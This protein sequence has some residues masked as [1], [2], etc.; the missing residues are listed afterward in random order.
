M[1]N[2]DPARSRRFFPILG[3]ALS[4]AALGGVIITILIVLLKGF[5]TYQNSLNSTGTNTDYAGGNVMLI[6]PL[7][8]LT[9]LLVVGA[10]V[11]AVVIVTALLNF[12]VPPFAKTPTAATGIAYIISFIVIIPAHVGGYLFYQNSADTTLGNL[13]SYLS[14]FLFPGLILLFI[15]IVTAHHIRR[16]TFPAP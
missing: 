3:F 11:I 4:R 6:M 7:Y 8:C 1:S 15:A 13:T 10:F 12:T 16:L 2:L 5:T 14:F 9:A